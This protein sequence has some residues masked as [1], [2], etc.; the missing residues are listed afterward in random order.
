V[1]NRRKLVKKHSFEMATGFV[2][3]VIS[4][5]TPK[6]SHGQLVKE[7]SFSTASDMIGSIISN[8]ASSPIHMSA[9]SQAK[10][11]VS[12]NNDDTEE[13]PNKKILSGF[14]LQLY[15]S[16]TESGTGTIDGDDAS[17][18][19]S[20]IA[21][22]ESVSSA[23]AK[24][25]VP[26]YI[27]KGSPSKEREE[28]IR[29]ERE[30]M[31]AMLEKEKVEKQESGENR[32]EKEEELRQKREEEA[33]ERAKA[34]IEKK[35]KEAEAEKKRKEEEAEEA[36]KKRK[37]EEAEKKRKEEEAEKKRK[38]EEEKAK[39]KFAR[40]PGQPVDG[41]VVGWEVEIEIE[42]EEQD[43]D[44]GDIV[45][46][47][48]WFKGYV[49]EW[50]PYK[51]DANTIVRDEIAV[52]LYNNEQ[53]EILFDMDDEFSAASGGK[54]KDDSEVNKITEVVKAGGKG[55]RYKCKRPVG[56]QTYSD[57]GGW[58][59]RARM[60]FN[61]DGGSFSDKSTGKEFDWARGHVCGYNPSDDIVMVKFYNDGKCEQMFND[62]YDE[63]SKAGGSG[64][65]SEHTFFLGFDAVGSDIEYLRVR[66]REKSEDTIGWWVRAFVVTGVSKDEEDDGGSEDGEE[67]Y[68]WVE[69]RVA[70]IAPSKDDE[71]ELVYIIKVIDEEKTTEYECNTDVPLEIQFVSPPTKKTE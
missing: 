38:E 10:T 46:E 69:G 63:D 43:V 45:A 40:D 37:E 53:N 49:I 20:S 29:L 4:V 30:R 21:T 47:K 8:A 34:K 15:E 58:E 32:L 19:N 27:E 31:T 2:D 52:N 71:D 48:G 70:R 55:V 67:E 60:E 64:K 44:R 51:D 54:N 61:T 18:G 17:I 13:S 23:M 66:P 3:D 56:A 16:G 1:E 50:Y 41:E 26:D 24:A 5:A 7:H 39:I 25:L 35:N 14:K 9:T 6:K 62:M 42:Y 36:A 33:E 11:I 12:S 59:V 65:F 22:R 28:E 57:G 68:D